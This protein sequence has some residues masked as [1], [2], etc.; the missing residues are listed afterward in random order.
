M[1]HATVWEASVHD[2]DDGMLAFWAT[3]RKEATRLAWEAVKE[4]AETRSLSV[5]TK[6]RIEL[7][8]WGIAAWLNRRV[9]ADND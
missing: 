8:S 5:A 4:S 6:H 3:T 1:K 9:K 2:A 7:S